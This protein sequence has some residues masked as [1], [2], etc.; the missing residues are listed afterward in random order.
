VVPA[1][2]T[3]ESAVKPQSQCENQGDDGLEH[4][5]EVATTMVLYVR[6]LLLQLARCTYA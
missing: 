2:T 1:A 6:W 4:A 3:T 5:P